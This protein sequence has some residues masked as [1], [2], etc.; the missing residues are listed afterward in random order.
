M[1]KVMLIILDLTSNFRRFKDVDVQIY[2]KVLPTVNI[3]TKKSPEMMPVA[4][5]LNP[6]HHHKRKSRLKGIKEILSKKKHSGYMQST[7]IDNGIY[8]IS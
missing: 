2:P 7:V 5:V 6:I 4:A 3:D 1:K 8:F